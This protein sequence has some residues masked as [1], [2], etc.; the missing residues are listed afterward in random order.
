MRQDSNS[1]RSLPAKLTMPTPTD[2]TD[3]ERLFSSIDKGRQRPI[4]W[5]SAPAGSGK[6]TLVASYLKNRKIPALWYQVDEGDRDVASIFYYLGVA[7]ENKGYLSNSQPLPLFTAE[8]RSGL[9]VFA[10][11]FFRALYECLGEPGILVLDNFQELSVEESV[12]DVLQAAFE[13]IPENVNIIVISRE[14]PQGI[15]SRLRASKKIALIDWQEICL[16]LQEC[17]NI[18]GIQSKRARSTQLNVEDLHRYTRGWAAGVILLT[19]QMDCDFTRQL[20]LEDMTH[21]SIFDYFATEILRRSSPDVQEFLIKT[22]YLP[23]VSLNIAGELV[24]NLPCASILN[25]LTRRNFFTTKNADGA[26]EYHPLFRA[27]LQSRAEQCCGT[28]E[29]KARKL[30][31]GQ[32]LVES[33]DLDSGVALLLAA[34][35]WGPASELLYN[36]A[37]NVLRQGRSLT[38]ENWMVSIP[39]AVVNGNPWLL[40][41]RGACR[42]QANPVLARADFEAAFLK[43]EEHDDASPLYLC[44]SRIIESYLLEKNDYSPMIEWLTRYSALNRRSNH[45]SPGVSPGIETASILTYIV[46]LT[47]ACCNHP[48]LPIYVERAERL[49][50][51]EI[52]S[53]RKIAYMTALTPYYLW[54]GEIFQIGTFVKR[55]EEGV[56]KSNIRVQL[57]WLIW[58]TFYEANVGAADESLQAAMKGLELA[59]STGAHEGDF[60]LIGYA[61]IGQLGVGN[62]GVA[63]SLLNRM[64][65][66]PLSGQVNEAMYSHFVFMV[67]LHEGDLQRAATDAAKA[68]RLANSCSLD[69]GSISYSVGLAFANLALGNTDEVVRLLNYAKPK[70]LAMRSKLYGSFSDFCFA[71]VHVARGDIGQALIALRDALSVAREYGFVTA[72][73]CPRDTAARLYNLALEH[74]ICSSYAKAMIVTTSLF[75]PSDQVAEKWPW[76]IHLYT[77][78]SFLVLKS[79]ERLV[80]S[81]KGQ[82]KPLE[83]LRTLVALGGR[84]VSVVKIAETLWPDSDADAARVAFRM[85]LMRLR[86][87]IGEEAILIEQSHVTLNAEYCWLDVWALEKVCA[88]ATDCVSPVACTDYLLKLYRGSFLTDEDDLCVLVERARL[89][90]KFLRAIVYFGQSLEASGENAMAIPIY[91]KGLEVDPLA[92]EFYRHL[93]SCYLRL[94][95]RAEALAVYQRCCTT[96]KSVLHLDPS[97][98]TRI[99][100]QEILRKVA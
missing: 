60:Q 3:R 62:V 33:G 61:I 71:A 17:R 94:N 44:W 96:L 32:L 84:Q 59:A 1:K 76:P 77:L 68:V 43:F 79:G 11:N 29:I 58:K 4:I 53:E 35:A 23:T 85:T 74:D 99:L 57:N 26:Y 40:Y 21:Q 6:T 92:E 20:R 97:M 8:Y 37:R 25:D 86:R 27:F 56:T 19:E 10:T 70:A 63:R 38:V 93:M 42:L 24:G 100:Y 87:L 16:T 30:R 98:E 50:Q 34:E 73:Y 18:V 13:Q 47:H 54:T 22:A 55:L 36:Y 88:D 14:E 66:L 65:Q 67:A 51:A 95:R 64:A 15:W 31:S 78:G 9:S 82:K 48:D 2:I 52:G 46:G 80:F 83:L 12:Q 28:E 5:I 72:A 39:A 7:A 89:R 69:V 41:L 81:G 49:I 91:Q 75:P 90:S 45:V